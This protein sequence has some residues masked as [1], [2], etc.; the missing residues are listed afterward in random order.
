MREWE[1]RPFLPQENCFHLDSPDNEIKI[2]QIEYWL[3]DFVMQIGREGITTEIQDSP[4]HAILEDYVSAVEVA[5]R[6]Y[7]SVTE[8]EER[9]ENL[10]AQPLNLRDGQARWLPHVLSIPW[11]VPLRLKDFSITRLS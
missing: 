10:P 9:L 3:M 11:L 8:E 6:C 5:M 1:E 7:S 4:R 2:Y